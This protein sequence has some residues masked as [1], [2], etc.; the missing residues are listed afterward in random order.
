MNTVVPWPLVLILGI[1]SLLAIVTCFL[2][3]Y[4]KKKRSNTMLLLSWF[5]FMVPV[6]GFSYIIIGLSV[7]RLSRMKTVD[8]SEV[9]FNKERE[10]LVLPPDQEVEMNYVP[11]QDAMAVSDTGS[12]RRLLLN[13]M[14]S[15]AKGKISNVAVAVDSED[16]EASHYAA[17]IV[18]DVLSDLRAAAQGMIDSMKKRPED[19]E[20]NLLTFDYIYKL[21]DLEVLSTVEQE[22]YVHT[23]DDIG[24]NLFI[25]NLWY[26]TSSHYLQMTDM[27][28]SIKAYT[29]ADKWGERAER[30]RPDELD[31][32]K[33][34]LHLYY[35][36]QNYAAFFKCLDEL[37]NSDVDID[38]ESSDLIDIYYG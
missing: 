5:I 6:V 33:T 2:A 21:L 22:A 1:N 14:L 10:K 3:F 32:Y 23:L 7:K 4:K 20:L 15:N 19:V 36:Q 18:T 37:K 31:T 13:T 24:E 34:R 17:T 26:M 35:K 30:Y 16:T 38:K 9:S 25:Y 8:I 27:S 12:L 29:M 11:I 28:I